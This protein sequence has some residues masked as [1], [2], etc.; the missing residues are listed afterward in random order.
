M[1]QLVLSSI[2]LYRPKLCG[3]VLKRAPCVEALAKAEMG[4]VANDPRSNAA[5]PT[6]AREER[7]GGRY[8]YRSIPHQKA[9]HHL[10]PKMSCAGE[11]K[12]RYNS[13][14][15]EIALQTALLSVIGAVA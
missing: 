5:M 1:Y 10:E 6:R 7:I 12:R 13:A 2:G 11:V 3:K 14:W 8:Q 9:A 4:V 15:C